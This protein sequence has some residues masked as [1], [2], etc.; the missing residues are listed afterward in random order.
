MKALEILVHLAPTRLLFFLMDREVIIKGIFS[1]STEK[2]PCIVCKT[3][4]KRVKHNGRSSFFA[5][6]AKNSPRPY[7]YRIAS[8]G[9]RSAAFL[10]GKT[11]KI[12]PINEDT[13]RANT[14]EFK[15]I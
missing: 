12:M 2:Q 6:N 7:S 4:I 14:I 8:I 13:P 15:S 10:A 1:L 11:P 9:E 5:R 3:I